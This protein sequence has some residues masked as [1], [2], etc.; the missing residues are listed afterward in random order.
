MNIRD[1]T[2]VPV[3]FRPPKKGGSAGRALSM[4]PFLPVTRFY[5]L[6]LLFR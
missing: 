6:D 2:A 4:P 3:G 1:G 5:F